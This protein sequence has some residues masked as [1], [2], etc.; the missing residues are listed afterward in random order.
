MVRLALDKLRPENVDSSAVIVTGEGSEVDIVIVPHRDLG[1]V[2]L[3]LWTDS[4]G[5]QLMWA[6]IVDLSG[7]N[8]EED[9]WASLE[10]IAT[11]GWPVTISVYAC[12]GRLHRNGVPTRSPSI[13]RLHHWPP[14]RRFGSPFLR[15]STNGAYKR[16]SDQLGVGIFFG[17][18]LF[19]QVPF[20][21]IP[22]HREIN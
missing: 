10:S 18:T 22:R 21:D 16:E 2:S 17:A 13:Q 15:P 5:T 8:I 7:S 4:N 12:S 1:G 11:Y 9:F 6:G 14:A 19:L 3:V 20:L